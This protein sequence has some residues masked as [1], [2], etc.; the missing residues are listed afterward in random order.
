MVHVSKIYV[1]LKNL[2]LLSVIG[3]L[4]TD[5]IFQVTQ[6]TADRASYD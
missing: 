4:A 3:S 6:T 2:D 5:Y 1:N